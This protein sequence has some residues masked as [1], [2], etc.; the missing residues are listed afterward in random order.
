LNKGYIVLTFQF[1]KVRNKWVALCE[2]MGTSTFGRSIQEAEKR[3]EE[4]VELHLD[5]LDEAGECEL[6]FKE[7]NIVVQYLKPQA[8]HFISLIM[9][10]QYTLS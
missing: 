8:N 7:N 5:T 6:F 2:E 3:L 10:T 9:K 1:S 4:A